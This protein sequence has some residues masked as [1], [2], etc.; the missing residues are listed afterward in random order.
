MLNGYTGRGADK[1]KE[2]ESAEQEKC[3]YMKERMKTIKER[4]L[5]E[6]YTQKCEIT[7]KENKQEKQ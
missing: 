5:H 4:K 3:R 6:I 1:R 7:R 2:Q